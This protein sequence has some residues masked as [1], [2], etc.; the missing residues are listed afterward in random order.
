MSE[1]IKFTE[2]ELAEFKNLQSKFEEKFFQF[3]Q[4]YLQK[5]ALDSDI[6][7]LLDE[8]KVLQNDYYSLQQK[9]KELFEKISTKYGEGSLNIK[10]GT[11]TKTEK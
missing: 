3:G 9:E 2:E 7:N 6:K 10:D 5:M 1:V 4:L 8:E 11:F